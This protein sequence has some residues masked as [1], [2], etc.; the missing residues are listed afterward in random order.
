MDKQMFKYFQIVG[1]IQSEVA[2]AN[3]IEEAIHNGVDTII[4]ERA[5]DYVTVWYEDAKGDSVLHPYYWIGSIDLTLKAS[6]T[7]DSVVSRVYHNQEA[8][9]F[10]DYKKGDDLETDKYF[11]G[12]SIEPLVTVPLSN[13]YDKLGCVQFIN[14][15]ASRRFTQE[16]ADVFEMFTSFA[17]VSIDE[18]FDLSK[19]QEDKQVIISVKDI[20]KSFKN[21][22]VVTKVLKGVNMNVYEGEFVVLLGESGC[23]KSTLLN[24][25]GGLDSADAGTF[26]FMGKDITHAN[27]DELT[28]YRKDNIGFRFQLLS[29]NRPIFN[30]SLSIKAFDTY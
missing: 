11:E 30:K 25:I 21:G 9:K 20:E 2:K 18:K 13:K 3:S 1:K 24:I 15:K 4:K 12:V 10:L 26:T 8:E 27:E 23:G 17:A 14:S 29:G 22:E 19:T 28:E 5:V 7:N 16:D 6:S